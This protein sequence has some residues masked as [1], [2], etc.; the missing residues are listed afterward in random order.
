MLIDLGGKKKTKVCLIDAV[1]GFF[2]FGALC[3]SVCAYWHC[4]SVVVFFECDKFRI[5][6]LVVR[7]CFFFLF[8][9]Y[10]LKSTS[11]CFCRC[12]A[13]FLSDCFVLFSSCTQRPAFYF[14]ILFRSHD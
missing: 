14:A 8:H 9:F 7:E 6:A 11:R 3:V 4:F 13:S 12:S 10:F 2:K 5:S 1:S